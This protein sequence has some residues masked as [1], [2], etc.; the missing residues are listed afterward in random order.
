[1]RLS[2]LDQMPIPKDHTAEEAFQR[3]E[4]I[5]LLGEELGY[6]RMWLAEHH[7]SHSLASSAPEVTAAFLAAKTKRLRIGTGGVMMMHYSPYKLAEVF[8]TLSG[9]AP[10]RIDFGVGRAPGGDHASIYALAEGRR[11]RFTEQYDKLEIILKL[12]N[13]Q[14]TGE[15]VYDQVIA[16][17]VHIQLPEAWLLGSSG[18]SAMQAGRFG[19]GYSY[20]QFFTGNMS[21]DIFDTYRDFFIPSYYMEKPQIIVTYAATVANT[22]EEAEYLAKPI[23]ITRLHLMKGQIIQAMSPEEAKDY[24]L[25][26]LDK[27]TIANNRKA[28]LVGTQKEVAEFLVAEQEQYGF[29]EVMLNC[30]QY[31]L[32]SRLNTY[33][34]IAKELIRTP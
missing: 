11:Q 21:K 9:L 23:D 6:H 3:T 31:A 16:A 24:P 10:N 32:E 26:E 25:T 1:M 33:K 29:D 17:P 5:A 28:N 27:M 2:I 4:Q 19:V 7:N 12:M 14:K 15:D 13:N 20:A 34:L 8:K 22:L 18:Q 30:N